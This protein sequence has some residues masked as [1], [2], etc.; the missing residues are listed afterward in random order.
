M[1]IGFATAAQHDLNLGRAP[2]GDDILLVLHQMCRRSIRVLAVRLL[3]VVMSTAPV[4]A[5][6][7]E[8]QPRPQLSRSRVHSVGF[9][10]F[11][12]SS[13]LFA[14]I[15][16]DRK[17]SH[18]NKQPNSRTK[19]RVVVIYVAALGCDLCCYLCL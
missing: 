7:A 10:E 16:G 8:L 5:G 19:N 13:L 17:T 18:T 6:A 3:S 1:L 14:E 12:H 4:P 11:A 2:S 9:D 15:L